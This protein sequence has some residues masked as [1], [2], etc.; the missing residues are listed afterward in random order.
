MK[1]SLK[2]LIS[3]FALCCMFP[4]FNACK[5]TCNNP[6]AHDKIA[7][8]YAKAYDVDKEYV[9][10]KCFGNFNG[11]HV[12]I[13]DGV[14]GYASVITSESVDGVVFYHTCSRTFEV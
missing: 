14:W 7:T 4:L 3:F 12:L 13:I 6:K 5:K 1:K 8:D 9:R 11:T 2:A 10:C